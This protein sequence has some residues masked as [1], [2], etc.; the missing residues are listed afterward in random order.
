MPQSGIDAVT[1]PGAV[2]GWTRLHERFG[3]LPWKDLFSPAIFYAENGY[4][5]PELISRILA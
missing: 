3:K 1:V 5:V 2:A 4:P